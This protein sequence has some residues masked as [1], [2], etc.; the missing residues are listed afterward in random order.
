MKISMNTA[1]GGLWAAM[2]ACGSQHKSKWDGRLIAMVTGHG[3]SP[4]VGPGSMMLP[5]ALL[6]STMDAGY[7]LQDAGAGCPDRLL[8]VRAMRRLSS[9]GSAEAARVWAGSRLGT[10]NLTSPTTTQAE[11]TS[12]R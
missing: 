9:P 5:G 1:H 12:K 3:S 11:R 8:S 10:A 7:S 4:G 2:A 6:H